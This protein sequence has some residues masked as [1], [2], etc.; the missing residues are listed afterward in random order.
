MKILLGVDAHKHTH[1]VVATDTAGRRLGQVTIPNTPQ[2][3]H[4]AY[5]WAC[6]PAQ[7]RGWGI[8]NSGHFAAPFAQYLL[9]QGDAVAAVS[10]HLTARQRRRACDAA[11]SDALDALAVA[12]LLLQ[13]DLC[14]PPVRGADQTQQVKLLI[15]HRDQVVGERTRL[16]NQLHAH[17]TQMDA[18]Y[19]Q[20]LGPLNT[21][22]ALHHCEHYPLPTEDPLGAVRA[23]LIQQLASLVVPLNTPIDALEQQ[24]QPLVEPEAPALL[25]IQ[26]ISYLNA[27]QLI[28]RVGPLERRSSAAGLARYAGLAPL[29]WGRAGNTYH[30]VDAC[31]NRQLNAVFHRIA[32]VQSRHNPLA[33]AYL[34][35]KKAEGKTP[36]HAF[37]CLKRR[38]VD[39]VYAVWKSGKPY[40]APTEQVTEAA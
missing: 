33:Q 13:E 9:T 10:P 17:L 31:G 11:K 15:Q 24:R 29:Q 12:R 2:G 20:K 32:Q 34:A 3:Y 23:R 8:E 6:R 18:P 26:G 1:T 7:E 27:A 35:K 16:L 39:I 5:A 19:T 40:E 36:K 30:R 4:Q 22:A 25:S 14:L 28:G 21:S 38:M 37:R